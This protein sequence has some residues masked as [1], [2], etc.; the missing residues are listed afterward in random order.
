MLLFVVLWM[1]LVDTPPNVEPEWA[2]AGA[3]RHPLASPI[4][5][6]P[7]LS[8]KLFWWSDSPAESRLDSFIL[9]ARGPEKRRGN[10]RSWSKYSRCEF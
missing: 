2:G 9:P 10:L 6:G 1:G 7:D 3:L 4:E 5:A 8:I